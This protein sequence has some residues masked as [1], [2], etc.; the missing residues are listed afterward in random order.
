MLDIDFF[1]QAPYGVDYFDLFIF[2]AN[3]EWIGKSFRQSEMTVYGHDVI[4]Q[5]ERNIDTSKF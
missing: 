4:K 2:H 3:D 1:A 5:A